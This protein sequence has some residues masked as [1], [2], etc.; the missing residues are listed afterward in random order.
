VRRAAIDAAFAQRMA[1]ESNLKMGS[2]CHGDWQCTSGYCDSLGACND[3]SAPL[4][5]SKTGCTT[6]AQCQTGACGRPTADA[7]NT[8]CCSSGVVF[9]VKGASYCSKNET[10]GKCWY[11][12]QCFNAGPNVECQGADTVAGTPGTCRGTLGYGGS[13]DVG[14]Q[15]QTGYCELEGGD[16]SFCNDAPAPPP[17]LPMV[18]LSQWGKVNGW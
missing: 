14:E 1:I 4:L 15:C 7:T 17:P 9:D 13:C 10:G 12:S 6:G 5:A 16:M 18:P 11:S 2:S 8:V 3:R